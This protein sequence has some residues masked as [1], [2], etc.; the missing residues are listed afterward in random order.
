MKNT[1]YSINFVHN[2]ITVTAKFQKDAQIM[3]TTACD[4]FEELKR[5]FPDMRI[6]VRPQKK[7][8]TKARTNYNHITAYINCIPNNTKYHTMFDSVKRFSKSVPCPASFVKK[9]FFA[10]FPD[11]GKLPVFDVDGN[12]II[13]IDEQA[14]RAV[15]EELTEKVA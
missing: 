3:G 15:V 7:S 8:S 11:F 5:R 10:T 12:P 13:C 14:G 1:G 6:V 9:W 4:T 2:T